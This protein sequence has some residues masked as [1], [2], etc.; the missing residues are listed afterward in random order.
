MAKNIKL[1]FL[2]LIFLTPLKSYSQNKAINFSH[3][4]IINQD[5]IIKGETFSGKLGGI[6]I[7]PFLGIEWPVKIFNT[8][9]VNS[10]TYGL[11]LEFANIKLYPVIL[12]AIYTYQNN[13]GKDEFLTKNLLN[14]LNTK[15]TSFG[16]T[17]DIL[18]NKY[19]KSNFTLP[20]LTLELKYLKI[21][22]E[23]S[24]TENTLNI[25]MNDNLMGITVGGGFTLHIFD[26]YGTYTF[27]KDYSSAGIK[28]RI[29][30]PLI[31][32]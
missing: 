23:I 4:T 1:V 16:I 6:F 21:Q 28:T 19:I 26:I 32:F 25:I 24:P 30:F 14:F 9:S 8:T 12:G 29:H 2:F 20:F 10:L 31:K 15:I 11:K 7:S 5:S 3:T 18:L 27:A 17:A 13:T 22:K